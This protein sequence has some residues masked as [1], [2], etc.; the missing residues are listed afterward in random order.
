MDV[1]QLDVYQR[2]SLLGEKLDSLRLFVDKLVAF[3]QSVFADIDAGIRCPQ[4]MKEILD[5]R[6]KPHAEIN[7]E[8]QAAIEQTRDL[9]SSIRNRPENNRELFYDE[10]LVVKVVLDF[11]DDAA[12][13]VDFVIHEVDNLN[14]MFE[15]L[16]EVLSALKPFEQA[17]NA[18]GERTYTV[19]LTEPTYSGPLILPDH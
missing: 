9:I 1:S 17:R 6:Q 3:Q 2:N 13:G 11:L 12:Y 8:L 16:A 18:P 19:D 5:A 4:E 7:S 10:V 14:K 15:N